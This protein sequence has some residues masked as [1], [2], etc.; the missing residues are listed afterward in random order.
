[1]KIKITFLFLILAS[2]IFAED[3]KFNS[4]DDYKISDFKSY[5]WDFFINSGYKQI[6]NEDYVKAIENFKKGF[7]IDKISDFTGSQNKTANNKKFLR[8]SWEIDKHK[9]G[10]CP[11]CGSEDIDYA[12]RIIGYLKRVSKFS[13]ARIKEESDRFYGKFTS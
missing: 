11:K 2:W 7:S 8:Y 5:K 6:D 1:M 9:L 3:L 13:E 12:T 4:V 10:K